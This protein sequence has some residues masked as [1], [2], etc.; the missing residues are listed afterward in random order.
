MKTKPVTFVSFCVDIDRGLLPVSNTTH[1]IH[2][3]FELYKS[4]MYENV[5]THVPLVLYSSVDDLIVPSHRNDSNFRHYSLN[6]ELIEKE[7]PNFELYKESYP[8]THK[9]EIASSL[10]YYTPLVVLKMKKMMEVIEDNPF[11]SDMFFWMDCFFLR[12]ILEPEFL[13]QEEMYL[14]MYDNVKNKLGD[15]FVLLNFGSRP[16]GF[17]WGGNKESL[18]KVY[19][20][21]FE[22]FF[23][24]LPTKLLTE[25]LIFKIINE[26]YPDL[27]HVIQ[28][29]RPSNYKIICQDFL[30]K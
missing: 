25:E 12:G 3:S 19:E 20:H 17:F 30:I 2:R 18:K 21:Y 4:G 22:I 1:T 16:F 24:Y 14:K 28:L 27:M 29:E 11:D 8:T 26:R 10:F 23:E 6:K 9:D 15:K 7:F 5:D 13:Y